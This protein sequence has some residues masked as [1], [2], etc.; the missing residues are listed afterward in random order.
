[1]GCYF[2]VLDIYVCLL[3]STELPQCEYI[4]ILFL[5]NFI[6]FILFYIIIIIFSN[7]LKIFESET[8]KELT[9]V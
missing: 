9:R 3:H 8:E 6:L 7:I 2:L 1:M 5:Y 4:I